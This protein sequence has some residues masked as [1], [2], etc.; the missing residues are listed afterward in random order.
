M[1]LLFFV[2]IFSIC[3]LFYFWCSQVTLTFKQT[4]YR[5]WLNHVYS[6]KKLHHTFPYFLYFVKLDSLTSHFEN[7]AF[8]TFI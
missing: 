1:V 2:E 7:F 4:K 5:T 3:K 8:K 6:K